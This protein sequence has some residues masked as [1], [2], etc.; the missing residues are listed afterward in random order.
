MAR[1][2]ALRGFGGTRRPGGAKESI[3]G[4]PIWAPYLSV[5]GIFGMCKIALR[6]VAVERPPVSSQFAGVFEP[7]TARQLQVDRR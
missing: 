3:T 5:I 6:I 1:E 4:E 7:L 2:R